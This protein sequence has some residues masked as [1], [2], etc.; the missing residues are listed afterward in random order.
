MRGSVG[1]PPGSIT[2]I[3]KGLPRKTARNT[4]SPGHSLLVRRNSPPDTA[5]S[6]RPLGPHK[7]S[8]TWLVVPAQARRWGPGP[9][10]EA[11]L[12]P[13]HRGQGGREAGRPAGVQAVLGQCEGLLHAQAGQGRIQGATVQ[14]HGGG[15][16]PLDGAAAPLPGVFPAVPVGRLVPEKRAACVQTGTPSSPR[17]GAPPPNSPRGTGGQ[18]ASLG[19]RWGAVPSQGLGSAPWHQ[20]EGT[21]PPPPAASLQLL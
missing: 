12:L 15:H 4:A 16:G 17:L 19:G 10:T 2:L 6:L 5:A 20:Q 9:W 14:A 21:H 11:Y 13:L 1:S 3:P 7:E 18:H 8:P